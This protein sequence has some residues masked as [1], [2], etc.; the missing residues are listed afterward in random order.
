MS[1]EFGSERTETPR[2]LRSRIGRGGPNF[3]KFPVICLQ[4]R[5]LPPETGSK[6]PA[7]SASISYCFYCITVSSASRGRSALWREYL[8]VPSRHHGRRDG[9]VALSWA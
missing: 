7:P 9:V 4:N 6:L 1:R 8:P 2:Q 5:E 3:A